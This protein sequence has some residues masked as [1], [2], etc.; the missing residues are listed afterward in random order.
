[1][2]HHKHAI[3][4][5]EHP[6]DPERCQATIRSRGQC[7]LK[8]VPGSKF[9]PVH[10]GNKQAEAD[11]KHNIYRYR[12]AV[13]QSRLDTI[14]DSNAI[15]SLR[16]EIGILRFL[17]Q[18]H[19]DNVRTQSELLMFST[20]LTRLISRITS[21]SMTCAKV[22]ASLAVIMDHQN[23]VDIA[24]QLLHV[25]HQHAP[26][27]TELLADDIVT[28]LDRLHQLTKSSQPSNYRLTQWQGQLTQHLTT[29]KINSLRGEIGVLRL[30]AEEQLNACPDQHSLICNSA[31]IENT[32]TQIE[33]LVRSCHKLEESLGLLLTKEAAQQ[34]GQEL[35]TLVG[36]YVQDPDILEKIANEISNPDP[37]M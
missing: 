7:F 33:T 28:V 34:Y 32:I 11:N 30:I 31:R 3:L 24:L 37:A 36:N 2:S 35:I 17:A 18:T 26:G 23:A 6:A 4:R 13:Y 10:G 20:P 1:M 12:L 29:D 5:M 16:D 8:A 27:I 9:C 21:L 14:T 22:E 19:L 25:V 15:K